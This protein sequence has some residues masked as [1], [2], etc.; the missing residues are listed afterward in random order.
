MQ[1]KIIALAIAGLAGT[2]FAQSNV[3]I[4]GVADAT[5]DVINVSGGGTPA[6]SANT[7]GFTRVSTNG[8]RIGFKGTES[9][10]NSLTVLFQFESNANFDTGGALGTSRDSFVGL[11]GEF[12]K[13]ILGNLTGPTRALA[14]TLDVN[15]GNDGTGTNNAIVGKLGGALSSGG[16]PAFATRSAT[17][18]SLFDTRFT[19]SIAYISPPFSG[20]QATAL[21]VAN[22]NKVD[23]LP[24]AAKVNTSA[25]DLGLNYNNGPVLVG[26]TYATVSEKNDVAASA[27]FGSGGFKALLG[28]DQKLKEIRLGGIYDFGN[29][30]LRAL[31]ARTKADGSLAELKQNVWGLGGTYNVTA[32]GKLTAQYYRANDLDGNGTGVGSLDNTGAK[33]Y[34]LGYEHS[35]SKRTLLKANYAY[36]K[37]DDK[38][39]TNGGG[40]YDF[41]KNSSGFAGDDIKVS[42]LQVGLRHSF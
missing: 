32:N 33:F 39:S 29:V 22:E 19:N 14:A 9:L 5:F 1:Q 27:P 24:P 26:L 30:T 37:N 28:S 15:A 35:L 13:V 25:Y 42:G 21:Y 10:G 34:S 11:S 12:G 31:Y 20:L 2:S 17:T 41:G 3:T 16:T 23:T 6:L 38:T 4:Y 7:P 40:G 18:S 36:L 8:S